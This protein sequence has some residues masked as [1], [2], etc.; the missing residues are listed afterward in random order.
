MPGVGLA[1]ETPGVR[2][3]PDATPQ[4]VPAARTGADKHSG[5]PASTSRESRP[6]RGDGGSARL[7]QPRRYD[8]ER[9]SQLAGPLIDPPTEIALVRYRHLPRARPTRQLVAAITV[10]VI[11][12]AFFVAGAAESLSAPRRLRYS[13]SLR[14]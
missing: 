7:H 6:D 10:V 14:S 11:Q 1:R 9:Y 8:Y 13:R 3:T 5:R 4:R 2:P 12:S